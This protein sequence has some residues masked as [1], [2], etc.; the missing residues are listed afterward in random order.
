RSGQVSDVWMMNADGS[1]AH[2][3]S[4]DGSAGGGSPAWS[5]DG[6]RIAYASSQTGQIQ[7]FSTAA[8][9]AQT[10][11]RVTFRTPGDQDPAWSAVGARRKTGSVKEDRVGGG[12]A[13]RGGWGTP[14]CDATPDNPASTRGT[15]GRNRR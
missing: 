2:R 3:V 9:T 8:F 1:G 11:V 12:S 6:Q 10:P 7:I 15:Y 4:Y 14:R 13:P 5:P